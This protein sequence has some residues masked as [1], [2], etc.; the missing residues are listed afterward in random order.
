ML[1]SQIVVEP[2]GSLESAASYTVKPLVEP[3]LYMFID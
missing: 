3:L 1:D 2:K